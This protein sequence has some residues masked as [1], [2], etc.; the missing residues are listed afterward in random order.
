MR[1]A[2]HGKRT[3][4]RIRLRM[5]LSRLPGPFIFLSL[6]DAPFSALLTDEP[7]FSPIQALRIWLNVWGRGNPARLVL[8]RVLSGGDLG[9]YGGFCSLSPLVHPTVLCTLCAQRHHTPVHSIKSQS[10]KVCKVIKS[11]WRL[12]VLTSDWRLVTGVGY[13]ER[14]PNPRAARSTGVRHSVSWHTW[15]LRCCRHARQRKSP[16]S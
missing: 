13:L 2:R 4:R 8:K 3:V 7:V 14:F 16:L 5:T 9:Q 12:G 1:P 15:T 11:Q 10:R 6:A